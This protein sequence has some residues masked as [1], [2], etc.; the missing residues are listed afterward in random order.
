MR[1]SHISALSGLA[2]G[3]M[4]GQVAQADE[5]EF[6]MAFAGA[7]EFSDNGTLF[8]G[9]NHNGAIYAFDLSGATAP[10]NVFPVSITDIDV[11]IA[12]TLGVGPSAVAI[13]DLTVHP[14]SKDIFISVSRIGSYGTHPAIV[15]ISQ[16]GT[17]SLLDMASTS[18]DKKSLVDFPEEE[19]TFR[20]RGMMGQPPAMRDLAKAD[21]PL[22]S[23]AIMDMVFHD[24]ELFVSG[25][26]TDDFLSSLRRIAYPFDDSQG[27][28]NVEMYHIAH[29]RYETRAPIRA[30]SIETIDGVDQLVA[31]YTC[32]PLVLIPLD[33]LVDGAKILAKTVADMG[34][35][36][37]IDMVS[38]SMQG[39]DMLFVTNNSRSPQ[40]IPV[41]SLNAAKVVTDADFERG[42]KLDVMPIM[43]YG[44]VG[45][46]VMF[47]GM[48]LQIAALG[49]NFFVSLTR[50]AFTGSLNLDSNASMFP[51]RLHNLIS[52]ED[53]P[54]YWANKS[55]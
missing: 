13:N 19:T 54:Q 45:S 47:D 40:A 22:S 29:D 34:N 30:M 31:A 55:E 6:D 9:D 27:I 8:V 49:E 32:S 11:K 15:Q 26:A 35:G 52:E 53:F 21:A 44:P 43:P 23:L 33:E 17:L 10:D 4:M 20:P 25:V 28:T 38:Y 18:F 2:L 48:S 42:I 41:A 7:L 37:P 46:T 39:Q 12:D 16:N 3:A 36:Q 5:A 14:V 50:D 24:N 1:L 51:N